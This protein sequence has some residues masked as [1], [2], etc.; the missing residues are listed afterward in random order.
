MKREHAQLS[1]LTFKKNKKAWRACLLFNYGDF[2]LQVRL[3]HIRTLPDKT[4]SAFAHL[5]LYGLQLQVS[6]D[7]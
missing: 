6:K 7:G 3:S 1:Y 4:L 5:S 2:I